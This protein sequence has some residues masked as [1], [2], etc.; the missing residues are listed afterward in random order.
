MYS[1]QISLYL[2]LQYIRKTIQQEKKKPIKDLQETSF[3]KSTMFNTDR[4]ALSI[5]SSIYV[6]SIWTQGKTLPYSTSAAYPSVL[7]GSA[8][9]AGLRP[10]SYMP[11]LGCNHVAIKGKRG[12]R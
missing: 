5:D 2:S 12:F 9:E 3:R 7:S 8:H 11:P 1:T 4:Y 10:T 6:S